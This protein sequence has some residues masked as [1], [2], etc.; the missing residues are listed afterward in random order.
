MLSTLLRSPKER[1]LMAQSS[2]DYKMVFRDLAFGIAIACSCFLIQHSP[3]VVALFGDTHI[4]FERLRT[5]EGT[6]V[7]NIDSLVPGDYY[8]SV[9]RPRAPCDLFLDGRIIDSNRSEVPGLRNR[10][11]L[12]GSFQVFDDVRRK[13]IAIDC[14]HEDGFGIDLTHEPLVT[15]LYTGIALQFLRQISELIIGPI[16]SLIIA[17]SF[18]FRWSMNK[19]DKFSVALRARKSPFESWKYLLFAVVSL[20]YAISLAHFTRLFLSGFPATFL[21]IVLRNLFF[22]GWNC[23]IY[24]H[25][26][27]AAI[28]SHDTHSLHDSCDFYRTF[29]SW[30]FEP[31]L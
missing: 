19:G 15:S 22:I 18:F 11:F 2:S 5:A 26:K 30:Q 7:A 13:S 20:F 16:S 8:I 1:Y 6:W 14:K 21:H 23:F 27:A 29:F 9:G 12:G 31:I 10:L 3:D 17:L 28:Y 25:Y 24:I 4:R